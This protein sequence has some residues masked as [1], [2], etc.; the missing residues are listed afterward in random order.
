MFIVVSLKSRITTEQSTEG[1]TYIYTWTPVIIILFILVYHHWKA[2]L[3]TD[4]HKLRTTN[5]TNQYIQKQDTHALQYKLRD[6]ATPLHQATTPSRNQSVPSLHHKPHPLPTIF[7]IT[8][9]YTREVQKAELTKQC[10]TFM[11]VD[12]LHWIVIEDSDKQTKLVSNLLKHCPVNSTL[13][14]R[15][16]QKKSVPHPPNDKPSNRGAS[17]RNIGLEWLRKV[18]NPGQIRGV[19]YFADD[20]NTY[21]IQ[22]FNEVNIV[23]THTYIKKIEVELFI[24]Y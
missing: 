5:S 13:L 9:T 18:Y 22:I 14:N 2:T 23:Y 16:T 17:Q 10:Q 4:P 19:V 3:Y 6:T 20:D 12:N 1:V 21:D 15:K 7:V 24:D 11:L 8:P